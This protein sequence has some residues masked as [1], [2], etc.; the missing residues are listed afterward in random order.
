M[1]V[2]LHRS[3]MAI[4]GFTLVEL[5][6]VLVIISILSALTL[7]GL[8]RA[9]S[10][11]KADS[12]KFMVRKLS[13]ALMEQYETYEDLPLGGLSLLQIRTRM[14]EELPDSWADVAPSTNITTATTSMGRAYQRYKAAHSNAAANKAFQ[15]AECLYMIVTESGLFPSFM[16]SL[17][18]DRVGDV[19]DDGAREF[20]DGWGRPIEFMR[21]APGLPSQLTTIQVP[22]ATT[23]HDP[24]DITDPPTDSTAFA[25]FPLIYSS[26]PDGAAGEAGAYGLVVAED[27]WP[28]TSLPQ[29]CLY[30]PASSSV[31]GTASTNNP[32]AYRDNITNH[33][34][35]GE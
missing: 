35:I 18:S 19:D 31:V 13:D 20:L 28:N 24:C 7:S 10:R 33:Q 14:R 21:W 29:I 1:N 12:T 6:V 26:G 32:T 15:G 11:T 5:L 3:R 4:R 23:N 9:A 16:E 8:A 22:N 27:G 17:K 34:L 30:A 2:S 25:L